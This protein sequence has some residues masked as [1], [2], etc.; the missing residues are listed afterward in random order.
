VAEARDRPRLSARRRAR[1]RARPLAVAARGGAL[2][3]LALAGWSG[4]RGLRLAGFELRADASRAAAVGEPAEPARAAGARPTPDPTGARPALDPRAA[5]AADGPPVRAA[6]AT[7][8]FDRVP[9]GAATCAPC[10]VGDEWAGEGLLVSFRSWSADSTRPVVLD[11]SDYLP[12]GRPARVLGPALRPGRGLE[13]GVIRLDFPG[14]PR[15]VS[16][17]LFGPDLVRRF[18]VVAWSAGTALNASGVRRVVRGRYDA[19]GTGVFREER[20]TVIADGGIDR[21]SLDGRGP[22]G[23]M[24]LVD[25]VEIVP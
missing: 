18:D 16:F 1:G 20:I 2:L 10:P 8:V 21:V 6:P 24:L 22:P 19:G 12:A 15:R 9:D 23:H 17:S 14:R 3:A 4:A 5:R 13:V 7:I 11:G 25:D